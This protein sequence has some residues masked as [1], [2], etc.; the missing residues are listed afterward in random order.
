MV[1]RASLGKIDSL[2]RRKRQVCHSGAACHPLI[3]A[4]RDDSW[5]NLTMYLGVM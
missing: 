2:C 5:E 4:P 1:P 3:R